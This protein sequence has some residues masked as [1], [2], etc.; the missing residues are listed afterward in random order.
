M[1]HAAGPHDKAILAGALVE[2][3]RGLDGATSHQL[4]GLGIICRACR[5]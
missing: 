5:M 1:P 4:L 3:R 2:Q